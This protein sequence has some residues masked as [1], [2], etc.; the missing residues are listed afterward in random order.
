MFW[1]IIDQDYREHGIKYPPMVTN[2]CEQVFATVSIRVID[3]GGYGRSFIQTSQDEG[4]SWHDLWMLSGQPLLNCD[5]FAANQ[6]AVWGLYQDT[7][8]ISTDGGGTWT[9]WNPDV[10]DPPI[11]S[12]YEWEYSS[13][14]SLQFESAHAYPNAPD[15]DQSF[16]RKNRRSGFAE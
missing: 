14:E 3:Y 13:I 11:P 9:F 10:V 6:F 15:S 7:L 12:G 8:F 2:T 16:C 1:L 5:D 4:K